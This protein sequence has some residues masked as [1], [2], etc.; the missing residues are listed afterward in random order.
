MTTTE[1]TP[2]VLATVNVSKTGKT[3]SL[4]DMAHRYD[5]EIEEAVK[6]SHSSAKSLIRALTSTFLFAVIHGQPGKLDKLWKEVSL[7]DREAIRVFV[8]NVTKKYGK[9][10]E[11]RPVSFLTF[12]KETGFAMAKYDADS[13]KDKAS[14]AMKK[15]IEKDGANVLS[16]IPMGRLD[17]GDAMQNAFDVVETTKRFLK[18][19]ARNGEVAQAKQINRILDEAMKMTDG[20]LEKIAADND[21]NVKIKEAR[22]NLAALEKRAESKAKSEKTEKQAA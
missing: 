16:T 13:E 20:D 9:T 1:K 5:K 21:I 12:N 4:S 3:Q 7:K 8:V 14:K 17:S 6:D 22:D 10:V 11:G 15:E 2:R 18:T 19:L